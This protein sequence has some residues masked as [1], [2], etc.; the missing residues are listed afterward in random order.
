MSE[1]ILKKINLR[2]YKRGHFSENT[3]KLNF[4]VLQLR[5]IYRAKIC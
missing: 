3:L 1:G 4:A 5:K 2:A